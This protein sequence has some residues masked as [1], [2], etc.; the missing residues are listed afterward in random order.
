MTLYYTEKLHRSNTVFQYKSFQI[1]LWVRLML[2]QKKKEN[3]KSK[4]HVL[5]TGCVECLACHCLFNEND[6]SKVN[7]NDDLII[8]FQSKIQFQQWWEKKKLNS[9]WKLTFVAIFLML[10]NFIGEEA[11]GELSNFS[12]YDL[13][14]K[15]SNILTFR[16]RWLTWF[17]NLMESR[18]MRL[19]LLWMEKWKIFVNCQNLQ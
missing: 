10:K 9:W 17:W 4:S 8:Y 12:F 7:L 19:K 15:F 1:N 11:Q 18:W 6:F 16:H 5:A 13:C 2:F 3:S 14:R